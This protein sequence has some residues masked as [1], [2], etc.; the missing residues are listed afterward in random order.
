MR[1]RRFWLTVGIVLT[2]VNYVLLLFLL[3]WNRGSCTAPFDCE[4]YEGPRQ[5][6]LETI[7]MQIAVLQTAMAGIGLGLAVVGLVGFYALEK[8]AKDRAVEVAQRA[9]QQYANR[10]KGSTDNQAGGIPDST[11]TRR[12]RG[13]TSPRKRI[14]VLPCAMR[15]LSPSSAS[16]RR[17]P[18]WGW[19]LW[20]EPWGP[21]SIEPGS[22]PMRCRA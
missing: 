6:S 3:W 22:G 13:K 18:P 17:R 7:S 8:V 14:E 9:I 20:R 19:C 21:K 4:I 5:Y 1:W 15:K 11:K 10:G 2:V 12:C 16:F